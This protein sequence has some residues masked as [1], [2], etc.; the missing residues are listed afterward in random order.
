[1]VSMYGT[2]VSKDRRCRRACKSNRAARQDVVIMAMTSQLRPQRDFGE[3]RIED[4]PSAK[5]L[6]PPAIKPVF[7]TVEQNLILRTLGALQPKDQ[8]AVRAV[9][10][11]VLG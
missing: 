6:K 5:L 1:M 8:S 7:A 3:V 9:L 2:W 10:A 11:L 4:W